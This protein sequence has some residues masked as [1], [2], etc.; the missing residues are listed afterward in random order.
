MTTEEMVMYD[1]LVDMGI[2]TADELNLAR[3]LVSG[4]WEDVLTSVLYIRTGY[5]S[6][7]QMFEEE[8]ED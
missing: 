7:E 2:A 4:S 6:I 1:Q 8:E 5:R 3:N